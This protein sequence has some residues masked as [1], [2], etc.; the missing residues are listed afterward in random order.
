MEVLFFKPI[1]VPIDDTEA[2][3]QRDETF[4]SLLVARYFLLVARY[5][6]LVTRQEILKNFFLSKSKQ[7]VPH[8]NLYKS[9]ICE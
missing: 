8:I 2:V 9:L 4:R 5:F 7:K 3:A 1:K 6:M